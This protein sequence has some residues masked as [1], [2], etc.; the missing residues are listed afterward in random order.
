METKGQVKHTPGPWAWGDGFEELETNPR[1]MNEE[2]S[3]PKY[4]DIGLYGLNGETIIGLRIDHHSIE[5][6]SK[7]ELDD[8]SAA[9]RALI[10]A[11]PELL[12]ACKAVLIPLQD[13]PMTRAET[14]ALK[15][16]VAAAIAKA[17]GR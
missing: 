16:V 14:L 11:A 5:W 2:Y 12:A 17:E 10:A 15:Q 6:D 7:N 4:A 13:K 1:N 9:D 3:G 8:L